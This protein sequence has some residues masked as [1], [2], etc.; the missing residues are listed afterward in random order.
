MRTVLAS[1]VAVFA[2]GVPRLA[3]QSAVPGEYPHLNLT[4][5]QGQVVPGPAGPFDN[6][7][8]FQAYSGLTF[9]AFLTYASAGQPNTN[10]FWGVFV[11]ATQTPFP[12]TTIPP[13]LFTM[14]PFIFVQGVPP[15]L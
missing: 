6:T 13:Q 2:L 3:A 12:T 9:E 5:G 14:P 7:G 10:V 15:T 1:L 11:S 4:D 8:V